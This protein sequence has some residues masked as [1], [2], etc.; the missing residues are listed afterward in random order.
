MGIFLVFTA[1][2]EGWFFWF[3]PFLFYLQIKNNLNSSFLI[4][5]LQLSYFL[6]FILYP[7]YPVGN[8]NIILAF[9]NS[10]LKNIFHST[11]IALLILSC[12]WIYRYGILNLANLKIFS[13]PFLVGIGGNSGSGKTKLSK[14]LV[15]ILGNN[16]SLILNGDDL[17][18]WERGDE[19]WTKFTHLDQNY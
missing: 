19:N 13:K 17:H 7:S 11:L 9:D 8:N 10:Y 15:S 14:A 18:K 4:I 5:S 16:H 6:Y 1:P 2:S 12:Y 3:L